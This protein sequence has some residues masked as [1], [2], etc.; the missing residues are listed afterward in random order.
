L[1][2]DWIALKLGLESGFSVHP[3]SAYLVFRNAC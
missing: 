3:G 2:K 1:G